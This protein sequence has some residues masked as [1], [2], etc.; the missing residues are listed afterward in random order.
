M[1]YFLKRSTAHSPP[2]E[3]R[4][5]FLYF[6]KLLLN[7]QRHLK[8]FLKHFIFLLIK[9]VKNKDK[10]KSNFENTNKRNLIAYSQQAT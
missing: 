1:L 8:I 3:K 2:K 9:E 7:L 4:Y 5:S 6:C 10:N